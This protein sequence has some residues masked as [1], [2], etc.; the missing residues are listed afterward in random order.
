MPSLLCLYHIGLPFHLC[1]HKLPVCFQSQLSASVS[2][3]W[4][5]TFRMLECL[6]QYTELRVPT[7]LYFHL[8]WR[9]ASTKNWWR[10]SIK[11]PAPLLYHGSDSGAELHFFSISLQIEPD[12]LTGVFARYCILTCSSLLPGSIPHSSATFSWEHLPINLT[13]TKP[14][15]KI[16]FWESKLR[17][18]SYLP[19]YS[20]LMHVISFISSI[21]QKCFYIW[22]CFLFII[23]SLHWFVNK[24]RTGTILFFN[25][26][27]LSTQ[28][29]LAYNCCIINM[30]LINGRI[31]IRKHSWCPCSSRLNYLSLI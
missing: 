16:Y 22:S 1:E 19:N 24:W 29:Y 13:D 2:L 6:W 7:V 3:C 12:L 26:C 23:Y 17:L 21:C 15:L 31:N 27:V 9:A 4:K 18:P 14:H 20:Q 8:L 5:M 28:Q 10:R 25:R 11:A 30:H